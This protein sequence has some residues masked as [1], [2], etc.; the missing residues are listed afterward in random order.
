MGEGGAA[1]GSLVLGSLA[2][3]RASRVPVA[4]GASVRAS[5]ARVAAVTSACRIRLSPTRKVDMPT[6]SSRARSAGVKMPLSPTI[7]RSCGISG[8]SASLV[9]SVVSKVRRLRLL[10]PIIGERSFSARSSSARSWIS[11]STSMPCAMAASSISLAA[12]VV[13][14]GHDDQD[15]VGAMGAG[16]D[17]LIGVEHEILAQH[18]QVGRRARRDHEIEMALERR[19]VGQHRQARRAAGLIGLGQRRRIEIGADQPLGRRGLLHLGDQRIVAARKLFPDRAHEAARRRGRL[20][21]A[22][23]RSASGCARLAAAISSRL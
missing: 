20:G 7:R 10:T 17:H 18:R 2:G 3:H 16:F 12:R 9:A 23:R 1:F 8:A 6:R 5:S 14:R 4:R 19:R 22:L 21:A 13:E 11:I 15:A